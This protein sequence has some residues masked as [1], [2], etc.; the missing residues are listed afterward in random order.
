MTGIW[1]QTQIDSLANEFWYV[2]YIEQVVNKSNK[3]PKY[4][5]V[6]KWSGTIES[7]LESK[8][9]PH[10]KESESIIKFESNS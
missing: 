1:I 5:S 2:D 4:Q 3:R 7:F 8:N 10:V 9:I 6:R